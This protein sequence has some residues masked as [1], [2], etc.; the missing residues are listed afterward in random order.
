[1]LNLA[2][3]FLFLFGVVSI[4]GGT[5]GFVK[6]KSMP[7][8][9]AGGASG[10]FLLIAGVLVST[11]H[12]MPGLALGITISLGLA[13]RFAPIFLRTKEPM[14]AG[15]M[16]VLGALCILICGLAFAFPR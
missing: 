6:A 13:G 2:R 14:P 1:M 9:V 8:L 3:I 5:V 16:T 4:A 7:S 11:G 12:V 15:V 10:A